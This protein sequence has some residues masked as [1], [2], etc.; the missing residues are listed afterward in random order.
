MKTTLV[1]Y[2]TMSRP[3]LHKR[4]Y[5]EQASISGRLG[6]VIKLR[7]K[8]PTTEEMMAKVIKAYFKS[9]W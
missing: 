7:K 8:E 4:V 5:E 2:P 1:K 9:D 3:V 6:S